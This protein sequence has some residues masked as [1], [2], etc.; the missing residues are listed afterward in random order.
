VVEKVKNAIVEHQKLSDNKCGT[1]N[2]WLTNKL[3]LPY[4]QIKP[5]LMALYTDRIII[6]RNGINEKLIFLHNDY[7]K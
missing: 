6:V 2:Y 4:S 1:T 5:I 7:L 3:Q